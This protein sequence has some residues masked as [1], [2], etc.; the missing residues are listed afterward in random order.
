MI[1]LIAELRGG[2]P[3]RCDFC[4]KPFT[5]QNYATPEEAG[6]WACIECVKRWDSEIREGKT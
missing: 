5:E 4:D 3:E 1:D 2:I 6:E